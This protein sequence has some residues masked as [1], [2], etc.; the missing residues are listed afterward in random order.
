MGVA[1]SGLIKAEETDIN[2][3]KDKIIAVDAMNM[4]YQFATTIRQQDGTPLK[5][6]K[7]NVTSHLTGLFSRISKLM[8]AGLKLVFVFD[9]DMPLLKKIERE[10]RDKLK[11]EA[12]Q[13][14]EEAKERGDVLEMKRFA[15]RTTRVS[16][17]MI[18]ESI[19]LI[20][21]FGLPVIRSPSE[22]EAQASYMVSKGDCHYVSSQDYDCLIYGA[23]RVVRNLSLTQKRKKINA[24]TYKTILPEIL[25]LNKVLKELNLDRDRLI[26]LAM[27]IGTDFNVGGVKGLG[28]KKGLKLVQENHDL[29]KLFLEINFDEICGVS[30]KEVFKT[31]KEMPV[32]DDYKLEWNNIDEEKIL[33]ILV[34][35]HEFN[36]ERITN[37][38]ENIQKEMKKAR[39]TSL[40]NFF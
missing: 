17:D 9:G 28:P 31:I 37:A 3:F 21:A 10:R 27:I 33:E 39:Q 38:L 35:N 24:L 6:S 14:F 2:K 15:S 20:Q 12:I 18:D 19:K 29:E 5:D 26:A 32:S 1:L 40:G 7:G 30:W 23:P 8:I 16:K 22:G 25:E 13:S 34:E 36:R 11:T 4:L